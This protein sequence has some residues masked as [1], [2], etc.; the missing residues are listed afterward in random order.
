MHQKVTKRISNKQAAYYRNKESQQI[1]PGTDTELSI[2][3]DDISDR[4][5]EVD[6]AKESIPP[7]RERLAEIMQSV[8]KDKIFH[9]SRHFGI[10]ETVS[11]VK[12]R[13]SKSKS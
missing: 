8:G 7:A 6:K 4:L 1:I 9:R 13:I 5:D 12:L 2:A 10:I 3:L 11:A